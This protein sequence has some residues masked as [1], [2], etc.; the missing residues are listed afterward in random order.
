M[1]QEVLTLPVVSPRYHGKGCALEVTILEKHEPNCTYRK[2]ENLKRNVEDDRVGE[3]DVV[4]RM[5]FKTCNPVDDEYLAIGGF[6]RQ[7]I[8][9]RHMSTESRA[10]AF[11]KD[12]QQTTDRREEHITQESANEKDIEIERLKKA[13][14]DEIALSFKMFSK[15]ADES[16]QAPNKSSKTVETD[17]DI[18]NNLVSNLTKINSQL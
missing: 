18:L 1:S 10:T 3:Y 8:E 4:G 15:I 7:D 6:G 9:A 14:L 17:A 16:V 2:N 11:M 13:L 12:Y 5:V